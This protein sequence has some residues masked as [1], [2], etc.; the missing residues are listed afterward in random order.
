VQEVQGSHQVAVVKPDDI[1]QIRGVKVGP[2]Y[3]GLWVIS[4]GVKPG[5]RVVAEGLQKV[6]DG[7]K[8]EPKPYVEAATG[9]PTPA[10]AA[11]PG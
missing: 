10:P 7:V 4:D 9:E 6:R 1:V 2:R 5:E 3:Q 11:T 8:V